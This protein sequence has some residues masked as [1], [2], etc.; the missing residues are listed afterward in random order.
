MDLTTFLCLFFTMIVLVHGNDNTNASVN[1]QLDTPE[2]KQMNVE[3]LN[4]TC[5]HDIVVQLSNVFLSI[6]NEELGIPN[7]LEVLDNLE[8]S[9]ITNNLENTLNMLVHKL[10]NKL[11][12]HVDLLQKSNRIIEPI[13]LKKRM[14]SIYS[15]EGNSIK[16][17][18]NEA[19]DI[20]SEITTGM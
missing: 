19:S 20:C 6:A 17:T 1:C 8:F 10:N 4:G 2:R 14:Y 11:L 16:S 13:L 3:P 5:L 15:D 18:Q 7:F 9:H 12:S